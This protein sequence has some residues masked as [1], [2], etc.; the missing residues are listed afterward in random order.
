MG[1][2]SYNV[3]VEIKRINMLPD[4]SGFKIIITII[5][6]NPAYKI[7]AKEIILQWKK[8]QSE[9]EEDKG[10]NKSFKSATQP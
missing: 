2:V 9:T 10:R 6:I 8:V 7:H 5:I 3:R 4:S 1:G